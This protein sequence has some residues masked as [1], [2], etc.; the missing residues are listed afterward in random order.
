MLVQTT[1]RI[2]IKM[3]GFAIQSQIT[4]ALELML[5][6]TAIDFDIGVVNDRGF[7]AIAAGNADMVCIQV[8]Q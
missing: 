3:V 7:S 1:K 5:T 8:N 4:A 2:E 6:A